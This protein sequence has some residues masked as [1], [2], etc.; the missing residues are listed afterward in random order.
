MLVP[1]KKCVICSRYPQKV[2]VCECCGNNLC[3]FFWW[4]LP[5][6]STLYR[7]WFGRAEVV[8][9][10][11]IQR[12]KTDSQSCRVSV[13]FLDLG[14]ALQEVYSRYQEQVSR[15]AG[16]QEVTLDQLKWL[17]PRFV[18]VGLR[19]DK[20]ILKFF[21]FRS[22]ARRCLGRRF[23]RNRAEC[24]CKKMMRFDLPLLTG[25]PN[26][27]ERIFKLSLSRALVFLEVLKSYYS[28]NYSCGCKENCNADTKK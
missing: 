8:F 1:K 11:F 26:V 23:R 24:F 25:L 15:Y 19:D 16:C 14:K 6:G 9:S 17:A 7:F 4:C 20:V 27:L 10:Q 21:S 12:W 5:V 18:L 3:S 22:L 13:N 28:G 2:M